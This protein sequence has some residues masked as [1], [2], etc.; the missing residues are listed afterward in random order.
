MKKAVLFI[1]KQCDGEV[2]SLGQPLWR[3]TLD[4]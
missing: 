3:E 1:C 2:G 4:I